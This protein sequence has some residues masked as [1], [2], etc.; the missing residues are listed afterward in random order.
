M[1]YAPHK[2]AY[3]WYLLFRIILV[4]YQTFFFNLHNFVEIQAWIS[5]HQN[6]V[7]HIYL[8]TLTAF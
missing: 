6:E 4:N 7:I 3:N 5:A 1:W 8:S 2:V